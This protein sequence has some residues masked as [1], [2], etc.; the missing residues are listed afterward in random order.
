VKPFVEVVQN[1]EEFRTGLKLCSLYG[2]G[3]IP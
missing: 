2:S 1:A 3:L